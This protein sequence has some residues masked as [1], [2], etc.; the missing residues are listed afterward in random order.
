MKKDCSVKRGM[1]VGKINSLSQEL[2]FASPEVQV[3]TLSIY[4]TSFYGSGLW[5]LFGHDCEGFY[6]VWNRAIRQIFDLPWTAHRHWI[7]LVSDCLH[8]KVMLC[9]R[10]VKFHKSL[11]SSRKSCVRFLS[12]LKEEDLRT[13]FGK[14]L[15]RI[16]Q[17]CGATSLQ[18]LSPNLVK[19]RMKYVEVPEAEK[20]KAGLIKELL[21]TSSRVLTVGNFEHSEIKM[22]M[23]HLCTG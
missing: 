16:Q 4:A 14:T 2:Y 12:K 18:E 5:D 22:M 20:W 15:F 17:E 19:K 10:Y 11:T 8:P 7:E 9:A 13:V 3:K 21:L 23:D 6:T 1:F